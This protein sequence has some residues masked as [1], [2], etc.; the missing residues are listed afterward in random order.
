MQRQ[1]QIISRKLK[2][3]QQANNLLQNNLYGDN[4][5]L[6]PKNSTYNR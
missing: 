4:K 6:E 2:K 3:R 5:K 1:T